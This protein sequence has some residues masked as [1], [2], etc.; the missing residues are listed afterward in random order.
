MY[1]VCGMKTVSELCI[2]TRDVEWIKA[3]HSVNCA[4]LKSTTRQHCQS[5]DRRGTTQTDS[6]A[7]SLL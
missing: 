6:R 4:T 3:H 7:P 2:C 1:V 5:T